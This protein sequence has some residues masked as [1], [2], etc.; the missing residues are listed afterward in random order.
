MYKNTILQKNAFEW[1]TFEVIWN[2]T[3]DAIFTK[4][5]KWQIWQNRIEIWKPP[6][7]PK[8][9]EFHLKATEA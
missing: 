8:I 1:N 6:L 3:K 4:G 5:K 9:S 7:D 2:N